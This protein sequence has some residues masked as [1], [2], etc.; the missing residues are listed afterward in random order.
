MNPAELKP[1]ITLILGGARSG[2]SSHAEQLAA[3]C[4]ERVLYIATAEAGDTEMAQRIA[5]HRAERPPM[6]HTAEAPTGVA[7]AVKRALPEMA[8]PPD[9]LLLDCVTLLASNVLLANESAT[10]AET[11]SAL[12]A[13]LDALLAL[14]RERLPHTPLIL[15]SNEV[16][17]GIVPAY[18]L[19]R[20]YQDL[21]GRAN[22]H[23]ARLADRVLFMVAGL[24]MVVK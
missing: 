19:G 24:P 10:P 4:G 9:A 17:L 7:A 6:W 3:D 11:E 23:L 12:L 1:E 14:R 21:L 5:I 18:P 20:R 13:E 16:G 22:Q 2:K 8:S 15:V